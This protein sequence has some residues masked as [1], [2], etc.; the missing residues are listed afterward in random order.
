MATRSEFA[1]QIAD[2]FLDL[3]GDDGT[4]GKTLGHRY[5]TGKDDTAADPATGDGHRRTVSNGNE[6]SNDSDWSLSK[7]DSEAVMPFLEKSDARSY[8]QRVAE[9]FQTTCNSI[10]RVRA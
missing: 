6:I 1:F 9:S 4:V 7:S 5:W 8:T 2:D 10:S 3:W